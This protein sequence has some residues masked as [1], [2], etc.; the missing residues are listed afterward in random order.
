MSERKLKEAYILDAARTPFG[1]RNGILSTINPVDLLGGL[2]KSILDRNAINPQLVEDVIAGCVT[3]TGEQSANIAR[4]AILSAGFPDSVPGTT[5]D[6]Q[7]GSSLQAAQFA[8]QGIM[9]G[10]NDLNIACGVESM[11]RVPMF[12]SIRS[13]STPLTASLR[14]RYALEEEWFSQARG[15]QIIADRWEISREEMD[16]YSLRS[17]KLADES[18]RFLSNE[19][20]PVSVRNGDEIKLI[21][22]DQGIRSET[23]MEKLSLLKPAFNGIPDI[24]AGNSSQISD[25]A[26]AAIICSE[27][28]LETHS[29][30]AKAKFTSFSVVGVDPVSMLTGP[31]KVTEKILAREK[32]TMDDI[33][34]FEVNEAFASVVIAWL[35]ETGAPI[36]NVNVHG[37]AIAIGHPLGA[38][39]GR[40]IST[41]INSLIEKRKERGLIA[42]CEGGGMAN[43]CL[44]EIVK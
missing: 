36:E 17:H 38:T 32:L 2:L 3:Q 26:S 14:E 15:A 35:R 24:T 37:G 13:D 30:K 19:I 4:N 16:S 21:S 34:L 12:S 39:G 43:A 6:R 1:R 10:N 33:D 42:I 41:M 18:R 29:M 40:L 28:F 23:S 5:I 25:G 11:S 31:I 22:Q 9:T 20:S 7:C 27:D 44:I 8:A